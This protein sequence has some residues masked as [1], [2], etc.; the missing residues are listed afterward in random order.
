MTILGSK[1]ASGAYQKIISLMP[2]HDTYIE[3]HFGEGYVFKKKPKALKSYGIE[4][5]NETFRNAQKEHK[6]IE[7]VN[8]RCEDFISKFDFV[9]HG[10]T[11]IYADPPYLH[12]TRS[13]SKK[14]QHEYSAG[15]HG[16]LIEL[17]K[18]VP[19]DVMISGYP[20]RMYKIFLEEWNCLSFQCMT[21]G[22]I[23]TECVWYN[24]D[25]K[26]RFCL[27]YA[28]LDRTDRQRI[29]RKVDRWDGKFSSLTDIE[30]QAI[31]FKLIDN[32]VYTGH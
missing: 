30:R 22:G 12:S 31:L 15:D 2:P 10:R 24:F 16:N 20:S 1:G 23:R 3:S 21:R 25:L 18:S 26:E 13:M 8:A 11:L 7:L 5:C 19:G 4:I 27:E 14:Y 28:G 9:N 17:L 29:K 6:G 32:Y